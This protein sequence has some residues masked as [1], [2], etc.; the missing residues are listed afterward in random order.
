VKRTA[1]A[2]LFLASCGSV[3]R[4]GHA[5]APCPVCSVVPAPSPQVTSVPSVQATA[6]SPV[7][8]SIVVGPITFRTSVARVAQVFYIVD[9]LSEWSAWCHPQYKRWAEGRRLLG[10]EERALLADHKGLR[11]TGYGALDQAFYTDLDLDTA[12]ARARDS[13]LMA[14]AQLD[15]E[16]KVLAHFDRVLDPLLAEQRGT[17][18]AFRDRMEV[19][20]P[21]VGRVVS[22]LAAFAGVYVA[23]T[24]PLYLISNT[25][26][27]GGGGG[28]NGGFM[29]VEAGQYSM[30]TLIHESFHL[31]LSH[32][33]K[34][35]ANAAQ[36]CG[37][38]LDEEA[39]HEG[40]AYAL[41]PGILHDEDPGQDA[42]QRLVDDDRRRAPPA[43]N[44][45][46]RDH[47]FG[48]ALRPELESGLSRKGT[49]AAFLGG[50][51]VTGKALQK[52]PW[53]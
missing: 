19:E 49:L 50:V 43:T 5:G 52:E 6:P 36:R 7:A 18:L 12:V 45:Y 24:L 48:L 9:Q 32:R 4:P 38:G 35:I 15:T 2:L 13:H 20:A 42:L 1:V 16:H 46:V 30:Q 47:R 33:Q 3:D 29:E 26:P 10:D 17:V 21:Q 22:D 23:Q 27:R 40:I 37:A 39:L 34:E 41:S 31:V 44:D 8:R 28:Y 25:D 51:C 11:S 53:P 14:D